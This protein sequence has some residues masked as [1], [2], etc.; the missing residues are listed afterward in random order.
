MRCGAKRFLAEIKI[1]GEQFT[2]S[3]FARTP[4]EARKSI[5]KSYGAN[6]VIISIRMQ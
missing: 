6:T 2:K 3:I 4:S 1:D 5:R